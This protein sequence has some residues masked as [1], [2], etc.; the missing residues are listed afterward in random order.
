MNVRAS[1]LVI[2]LSGLA[3]RAEAP[4]RFDRRAWLED[5]ATLK[6]SLER[7]YSHLAWFGSP[8][9]G[10]DLPALD[11]RTVQALQRAT[12]EAEA[13]A[14]FD[15][16]INAFHDGH[17]V[18]K[19]TAPT[20]VPSLPDP[21]KATSFPDANS[22]CAALGY[23]PVS[24]VPFSLPFE[25][26]VGF[27]VITDGL[28]DAFRSGVIRVGSPAVTVGVVRVPRF[29][30]SEL[31][32]LCVHAWN[33]LRA[34]QDAGVS[35]KDLANVIDAE[36]L[37]T[38]AVRLKTLR[39]RGASVLVVDLGGNGGGND[40]G[41]WTVRAF[42][43]RPLESAPLLVVASDAGLPYL[44]TQHR[45]LS[46][47]LDGGASIDQT[48]LQNTATAFERRIVA[49]RT[50]C[51]MSWV[52]RERRT[53]G[54]S[55]CTHLVEAGY[56]SGPL[57]A[58]DAGLVDAQ[59]ADT[60]Y[61]PTIAEPIRGTWTG[62]TFVLINEQTASAAEAFTTLMRDQDL[63]QTIGAHTLGA[64]CG[65]MNDLEPLVL[66]R[67]RLTFSM[68]NCVRLRKDGTDDVAG[69]TPD[70]SATPLP[71]EGA[72]ARALRVLLMVVGT[73]K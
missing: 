12:S 40:L 54:T 29:R 14:A 42:G 22:A 48:L 47:L 72:R 55:S 1:A 19:P 20:P 28:V 71:G 25:T 7:S 27:E 73:Q 64:G 13:T 35:P 10:V 18:R 3:A 2:L 24:K 38:F 57:G 30:A 65:F 58:L 15:A 62:K 51:D 6:Q 61:W 44:E 33:R 31:P 21:P 70:L 17:L 45:A 39:A 66:P 60:L 5:Y 36:W 23:A 52:W 9:G 53:W 43:A 56:F 63:A 32:G 67:S 59:V 46:T 50:P 49:A 8:Q 26:L 11:K 37:E 16:F 4:A 69:V 34:S 41:D 68:P